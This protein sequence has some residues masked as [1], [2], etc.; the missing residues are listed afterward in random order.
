MKRTQYPTLVS[1]GVVGLIASAAFSFV[2]ER[3]GGELPGVPWPAILGMLLL[4]I[5][6]VALGWP[7]KKWND[8]DRTAEIDPL[9]AARV[10]MM[11]KAAA[12]TGAALTGWYGGQVAYLLVSAGG[13]RAATGFGMLVAVAT[14]ALLMVVGL[15]VEYFC[16]LP[17]DD[18]SGAEPA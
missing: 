7:I 6:L 18:P 3:Y 5:V 2:W 14:A 4:S 17:P 8:G 1:W 12:V 16:Q 13:V 10:A 9:R 11:A 15:V